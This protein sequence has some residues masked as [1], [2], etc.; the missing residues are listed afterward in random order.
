[1]E[2]EFRNNVLRFLAVFT[3]LVLLVGTMWA[4]GGTGELTGLVTDPSGAV[5]SG[6]QVNLINSA[7]GDKR[8]TT[9]T[10]AGTY[11]FAALPVVGSYTLDVAP[12]GFKG[13]HLSNIVITVGTVTTHDVKLELGSAQELVEVQAG[14]QLVQTTDASVSQLIDRRAWESIPI[15]TRSQNELINL[16]AGALPEGF[17]QTFRGA[18]VNGT[19]SGTGNYLVEGADNNEQGQGGVALQG[20]GGANTT[21]SPD[22]IQEYRVITNDFPAEYGKAGGFVTDTV[23]KSGT[24]RWHGSAFEYNRTQAYTA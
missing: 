20:P 4:Q 14:Q 13:V 3:V 23:L 2:Y 17:N 11:R 6:A 5:V 8:T 22:A 7:T 16:V 24:N 18:S 21:I 10:G 12:K 1:M 9:T 19:R 15:E